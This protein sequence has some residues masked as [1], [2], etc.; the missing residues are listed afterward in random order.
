M[1]EVQLYKFL[2]GD[3]N[4][5]VNKAMIERNGGGFPMGNVRKS[6]R[7]NQFRGIG[8]GSL[9]ELVGFQEIN[10]SQRLLIIAT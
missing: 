6:M 5:R 4:L 10:L 3:F 1:L 7:V 8:V 9:K 2:E